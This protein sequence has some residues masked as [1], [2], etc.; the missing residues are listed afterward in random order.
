M[1]R[2]EALKMFLDL[3]VSLPTTERSIGNIFNEVCG[4][5]HSIQ[6]KNNIS[7]S[8]P[9]ALNTNS[10]IYNGKSFT[11]DSIDAI[12]DYI[13]RYSIIRTYSAGVWF[14]KITQRINNKIKVENARRMY[15]WKTVKSISLSGC[16]IYGIV[17]KESVIIEPVE[18]VWIEDIEII[19]CSDDAIR[20]IQTAPSVQQQ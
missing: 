3:A 20:S 12:P 13:N 10:S 14:G 5:V 15:K 8:I 6:P 2:D 1:T 4:L 11:F 16:A 17:H 7:D 9:N 19:K 18:S